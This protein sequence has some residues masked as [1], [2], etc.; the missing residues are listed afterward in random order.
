MVTLDEIKN[1]DVEVLTPKMVSPILK[2]SPYYIN[3][4]AKT[5][6]EQLGFPVTRIGNRVKI[7]KRAFVN[8]MERR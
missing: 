5:C 8:Y 3:I 7:P 6:P 4:A 2:C 1:L